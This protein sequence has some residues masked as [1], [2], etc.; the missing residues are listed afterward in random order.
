MHEA[1]YDVSPELEQEMLNY[2]LFR[3]Q[4]DPIP[5]LRAYRILGLQSNLR[6]LGIFSLLAKKEGKMRYLDLQPRV[7]TYLKRNLCHPVFDKLG[8]NLGPLIKDLQTKF[9]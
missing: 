2:Y 4:D 7:C 6:I 9:G 1:L 3:S 5:F 8:S